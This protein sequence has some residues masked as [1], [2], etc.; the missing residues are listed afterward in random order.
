MPV[1]KKSNNVHNEMVRLNANLLHTAE[2]SLDNH[3]TITL[4]NVR[5]IV[6]KLPDITNDDS[7]KCASIMCFC[8][9]WLTCSTEYPNS[10]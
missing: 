9:T 7:L 1:I 5:S 4:L 6:A 3:V 10:Y 2:A 8:E